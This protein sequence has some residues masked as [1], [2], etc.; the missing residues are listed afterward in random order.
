ME[1]EK[2]NSKTAS[3]REENIL[4]FGITINNSLLIFEVFGSRKRARGP[5]NL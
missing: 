4:N 3:M 1:A 5:F 2:A